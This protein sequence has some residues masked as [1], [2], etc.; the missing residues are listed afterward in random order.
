VGTRTVPAGS[1]AFYQAPVAEQPALSQ[2]AAETEEEGF[3]QTVRYLKV[4]NE[5]SQKLTLWVRYRTQD[6]AEEWRWFPATGKGVCYELDPGEETYLG[7]Q[8][9]KLH[10][11]R[12]RIWAETAAGEPMDE[13]RDQDLWLVPEKDGTGEHFYV[14]PETE[15]FTFI[16]SPER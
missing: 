3:A 2:A 10:A 7:H 8:G 4:K 13:Y 5:T 12:V 15:D 9:G 6:A 11:S 1:P 16:F 14:A